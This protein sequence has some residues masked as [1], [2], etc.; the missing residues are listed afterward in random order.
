MTKNLDFAVY[1]GIKNNTW[2]PELAY[3]K[4]LSNRLYLDAT[5]GYWMKDDV[6]DRAITARA[7][8]GRDFPEL[9]GVDIYAA[10]DYISDSTPFGY[11][12]DNDDDNTEF[13]I[14]LRKN[15]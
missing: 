2:Y 14:G 1:R 4:F 8:L 7:E 5:L 12:G 13:V 10:V 11:D 9:G 3:E 15:F 6:D